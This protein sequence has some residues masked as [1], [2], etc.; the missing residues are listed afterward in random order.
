LRVTTIALV[1]GDHPDLNAR[2]LAVF[3][4]CYLNEGL[5]TNRGLARQLNVSKAAITR[6]LDRLGEFSLIVRKPDPRDARSITVE[7]T[8]KGEVFLRDLRTILANAATMTT[9]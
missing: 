8:A 7:R 9:P 5:H 2:Q 6:A 1:A 4:T 3:L